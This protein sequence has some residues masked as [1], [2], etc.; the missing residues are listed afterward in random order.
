[1]VAVTLMS[2]W[3]VTIA[4][5]IAGAAVLVL[6]ERR[7]IALG[8]IAAMA[9]T[10]AFVMILTLIVPWS[11]PPASRAL[12]E[13]GLS[14]SHAALSAALLGVIGFIILRGVGPS[15]GAWWWPRAAV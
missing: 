6:A 8:L 7:R 13:G 11:P 5:T 15:P 9:A 2:G 1:M 4:I 3:P 12:I 14:R 10:L